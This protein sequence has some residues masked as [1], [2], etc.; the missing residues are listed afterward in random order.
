MNK[1]PKL[2]FLFV[3]IFIFGLF[4]TKPASADSVAVDFKQC[5][6]KPSGICDWIGSILQSS[7]SIFSEGMSVPQRI[8]YRNVS[9]GEHTI[10]FK[11]SYTKG[12]I[13]AYDFITTIGQDND[14]FTPGTFPLNPCQGLSGQDLTACN[15]L[16]PDS[17]ISNADAVAQIPL[18][19]FDSATSGSSQSDKETAYGDRELRIY[20]DGTVTPTGINI[21]HDV[22][23]N[24]DTGDSDAQLNFS[25]NVSGC[26]GDC[27][28]LLYFG[29]H[30]AV[31]GTDNTTGV[32]WG[33][34]L[35]SSSISGGPYHI[36]DLSLDG[37]GG[38]LDNQ[39]QGAD[40]IV[41]QGHIKIVK[42]AENNNAQDFTFHNNFGNGNPETFFLDDDSSAPG[43][44]NTYSNNRTFDVA[45]GVYFVSEDAVTGW[46]QESATCDNGETNE[47]FAKIVLIKNTVGGDGTFDFTTTGSGLPVSTQIITSGNTGTV[48]F[49]D[50]DQDNTYSISEIVPDGW[51]LTSSSCTGTNAP[52]SITPNAGETVTCTFINSKKPQL[53]VIKHVIT[54]NGGDASADD[55]TMNVTGTNVSDNSFPGE[56]AGTTVTLDPGAYSVDE[57]NLPGYAK[58]STADCAGTL[59]FG[60]KKTCTI[61]NDDIAP[62]LHLRKV[63]INDNGGLATTANVTL[64]AEGDGSNDLNG[65]SPVDSDS[66]LKADTFELSESYFGGYQSSDWVC[67]G[68]G[69][70]EGSSLTLG[71]AEEA[72]C[73]ITNN[74]IPPKL[75]LRKVVVNDNG[76]ESLSSDWTLIANGD[77]DN[78]ISGSTPVDSGDTLQVGTF[79]LSESGPNG[80]SSSSWVCTDPGLGGL[81]NGPSTVTLYNGG[82]TTCTITND[83]IAPELT[84][85]KHVVNDNGGK[86]FASDFGMTVLG[87]NV[88][89]TEFPGDETGTT[90]TLKAGSYSVGENGISTYDASYSEDCAGSIAIG[91]TKTCTIT[92]DDQPGT[93]IVKK[94]VVGSEDDESIFSFSVNEATS[95]AFESDGENILTVDAGTY[96][97]TEPEVDGYTASYD[98]C[99]QLEIPNGGTETCTI[100]NT[101]KGHIIVDKITDPSADPQVFGFSTTGTG[102]SSFSLTDS[103][104]PN[105]QEL[106]PGIYS[107]SE[108]SIGGWLKTSA[109]CSDGSDPSSIDL[110]AGEVVTCTFRNTKLGSLNIIKDA[111]PDDEQDFTFTSNI[112]GVS[113]FMLDNDGGFDNILSNSITFDS[114]LPS[115]YNIN[116]SLPNS[117]WSL[118][119]ITC[120]DL[121]SGLPYPITT[122]STGVSVDL[123]A[124]KNVSC[125]FVNTKPSPTRTQGFWQTHTSF[126]S[127]IF[128]K[129]EMQKYV[130]VTTPVVSGSHKGIISNDPGIGSSHLFGVFYSNIAKTTQNKNRTAIDKTRMQLLQQLV[131][132]KLNCAAFG[133]Q[134]SIMNL[135]AG[136]DNA[137]AGT[138]ASLIQSFI[139]QLDAYNNS[140]DTLAIPSGSWGKATPQLSQS[141][142]NKAFW[143]NP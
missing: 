74:D 122:S 65:N 48:T 121:D 20:S 40:I 18:D 98:N 131:A 42:D 106:V 9:S 126:T 1:L 83:D 72:T 34:S 47:Q 78:D 127:S 41:P 103:Q 84:V 118:D 49:N 91:Q 67:E 31:G 39:I 28:I 141:Y 58:S 105:D 23:N 143:D 109:V 50:V 57:V 30:L 51:V 6:N 117:L 107:V 110:S 95:I 136:A 108:D 25:F 37:S 27:E 52:S 56:E 17:T 55:F 123:T 11:Y 8:L 82:E 63:V 119:S 21:E 93:L 113:T 38:S 26:S 137:Y 75:H 140:G 45:P 62:R 32:N 46:Q 97:V 36:K 104:T 134:T 102:Y 33:P 70:Q 12:G 87:T 7:N 94:I 44:N 81:I 111:R 125:T 100:T 14:L 53:T 66:S 76:G 16:A 132:A 79:E 80:Y 135:I 35:G 13:H 129:P 64:T 3:S 112:L 29:G 71:I 59:A 114:L 92:N 69:L 96:D 142:A 22:A 90:V 130:G 120:D 115:I 86:A 89:D 128:A 85:I 15:S 24:G 43:S 124:G 138:S 73:T 10:S 19:P 60:D 54:D 77:G 99:S 68:D 101:K 88:S 2:S 133:C 5:A 139:G 61:T 116:E 4:F